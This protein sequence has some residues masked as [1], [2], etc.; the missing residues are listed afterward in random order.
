MQKSPDSKSAG[1]T[2]LIVDDEFGIVEVLEYILADAGYSVVSALN[3]QDALARLR[4]T[5]PD[6]IILDYMMPVMDGAALIKILR[7]DSKYRS[8]PVLLSSALPEAAIREHCDGY[9]AFL[10]KPYKTEKLIETIS[11]LVE[12]R[13]RAGPRDA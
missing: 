7:A 3:G 2:I 4:E 11:R 9:D 12:G 6:L 10:R 13:P 5:V 1:K 8:I